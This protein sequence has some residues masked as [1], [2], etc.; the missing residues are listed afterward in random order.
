LKGVQS[1]FGNKKQVKQWTIIQLIGWN[2]LPFYR[3]LLGSLKL[4]FY[5]VH[6]V[7]NEMKVENNLCFCNKHHLIYNQQWSCIDDVEAWSI[8]FPYMA[9]KHC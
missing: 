6:L 5:F 3:H 2:P 9:T 1:T 8:V 7:K 4:S